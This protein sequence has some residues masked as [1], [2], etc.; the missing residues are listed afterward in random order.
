MYA[1]PRYVWHCGVVKRNTLKSNTHLKEKN[2][3]VA[4]EI[5]WRFLHLLIPSSYSQKALRYS[6]GDMI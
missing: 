5:L 1:L 2:E 3:I 4:T 6:F